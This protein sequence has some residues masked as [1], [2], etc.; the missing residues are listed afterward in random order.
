MEA[1]LR[2]NMFAGEPIRKSQIPQRY[3]RQFGLNNLFR[4]DHPEG[5]RSLYSLINKE[6]VGVCPLIIEMLSHAEYDR[7][8]GYRTT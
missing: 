8:F 1:V 7:L 2:E 4:Y 6:G 3:V 5:N